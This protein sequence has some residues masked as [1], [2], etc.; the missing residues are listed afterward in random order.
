M[1]RPSKLDEAER[2]LLRRIRGRIW[3]FNR[4]LYNAELNQE[5][6][7]LDVDDIVSIHRPKLESLQKE[8]AD[9]RKQ[10]EIQVKQNLLNVLRERQKQLA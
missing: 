10:R 2:V 5:M 1:A 7:E 9:Y 6:D 4:D 8:L 3:A